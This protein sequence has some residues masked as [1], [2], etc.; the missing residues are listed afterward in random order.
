MKKEYT[1]EK[2][3]AITSAIKTQRKILEEIQFFSKV[4]LVECPECSKANLVRT[5]VPEFACLSCGENKILAQC[6]EILS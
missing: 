6:G 1:E 5:D 2:I 4:N 3:H